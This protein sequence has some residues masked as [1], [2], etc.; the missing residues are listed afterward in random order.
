MKESNICFNGF[1]HKILFFHVLTSHVC[2]SQPLKHIDGML[3]AVGTSCVCCLLFYD[4]F[5]NPLFIMYKSDWGLRVVDYGLACIWTRQRANW[6]YAYVYGRSSPEHDSGQLQPDG[7][8][9]RCFRHETHLPWR[10]CWTRGRL[11]TSSCL[12]CLMST[13]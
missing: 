12:S 8:K 7:N 5:L 9:F 10:R 4:F 11:W 13:A 1:F 2:S 6:K 3:G